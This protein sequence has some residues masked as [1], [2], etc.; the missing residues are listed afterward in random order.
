MG[1]SPVEVNQG[2]AGFSFHTVNKY[3]CP[4]L[5]GTMFFAILL[6]L[7]VVILLLKMSPRCSV[8]KLCSV[9][10]PK[11]AVLCLAE[12]VHVLGELHSSTSYRTVG[13]EANVLNQRYI[14]N[15]VSLNR[16]THKTD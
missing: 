6:L 4:D 16:N 5:F 11:K 7:L 13:C 8:E 2:N 9:P 10:K 1:T 14:L 3:P 15:E 12:K